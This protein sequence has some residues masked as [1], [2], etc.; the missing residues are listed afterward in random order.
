MGVG[1]GEIILCEC[2]G[3]GERTSCCVGVCVCVT[4]LT[5]DMSMERTGSLCPYRERK[6]CTSKKLKNQDKKNL[7][8]KYEI[9]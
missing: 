6:N 7:Q 2:V 5:V 3:G 9:R 4:G 8:I 1:V